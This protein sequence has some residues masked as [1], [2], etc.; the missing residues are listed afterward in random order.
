MYLD[1][2]NSYGR[3]VSEKLPEDACKQVE[4]TSDFTDDSINIFLIKYP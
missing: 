1:K 4:D 2:N 3:P